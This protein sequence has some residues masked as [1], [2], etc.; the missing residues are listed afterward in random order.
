M[1]PLVVGAAKIILGHSTKKHLGHQI[2]KEV[3]KYAKDKAENAVKD[4]FKKKNKEKS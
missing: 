1:L 4:Q 3:K 2:A